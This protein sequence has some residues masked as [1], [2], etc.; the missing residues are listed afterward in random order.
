[1]DD[2]VPMHIGYPLA[3]VMEISYNLLLTKVVFD[4]Y[5]CLDHLSQITVFCIVHDHIQHFLDLEAVSKGYH[6]SATECF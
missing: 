4:C 3:N 6:M 5:L 1:M 2:V